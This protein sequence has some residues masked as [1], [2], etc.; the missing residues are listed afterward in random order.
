MKIT[1]YWLVD[2]TVFTLV[3]SMN[4]F[5][6]Q[7]VK[8]RGASEVRWYFDDGLLSPVKLDGVCHR[9]HQYMIVKNSAE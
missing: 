2:K 8:T 5:V 9:H 3:G 7:D 6:F 4:N 1:T